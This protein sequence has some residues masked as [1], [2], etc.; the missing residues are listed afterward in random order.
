MKLVVA[1]LSCSLFLLA[2]RSEETDMIQSE[3]E[4]PD[5]NSDIVDVFTAEIIT[6]HGKTATVFADDIEGYPSGVRID[7]VL[8]EDEEWETGEIVRVEHEGIFME[9]DP[10][11]I[12]QIS[13]DKVE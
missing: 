5:T 1:L 4:V 7:I 3:A 11:Q 10:V 2:C 8:S 12:N 9:S 13:V 6:I